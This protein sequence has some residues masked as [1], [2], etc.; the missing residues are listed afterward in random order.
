MPPNPA[1]GSA[2]EDL[3]Q[4]EMFRLLERAASEDHPN[5]ERRGCPPDETLEAFAHN[6]RAFSMTDPIFEH[7]QNCSPCF[8]FVR[9]RRS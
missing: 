6:P 1:K 2:R 9:E 5:P 7:V 4:E 8:R 3:T